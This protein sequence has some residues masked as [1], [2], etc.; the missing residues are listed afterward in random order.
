MTIIEGHLAISPPNNVPV[1]DIDPYDVEI[2]KN[3]GEYYEELIA[4][5]PFVYIPKYSVLACGRYQEVKEVFSDWKRFVSSRGVGLNDF[6]LQKPWRDPSIILEADP[7]DHTKTRKILSRV[8]SPKAVSALKENFR[9]AAESLIDELLKREVFDAV[10]DM[11]EVFPTSVFPDFVGLKEVNKRYLIDYGA[12]VFNALGPDN[13]LR[14]KAMDRAPEIVS[15]IMEQCERDNLSKH[16]MGAEIYSAADAGEITE[17]EAGMLVR[18]LLS[19]GVDTTVTGIGSGIYCLAH[20]PDQFALL[21]ENPALARQTFE[22]VLRFT[23]PVHSFCRTANQDTT[24]SDVKIREGTKIICVLGAANMDETKWPEATKFDVGRK[25]IGHLAFGTG[26]HGCVG[27][28]IARG[29]VEAILTALARKVDTIEPAG[30]AVWRP[31]N[32]IHALGSFPVTFN[33]N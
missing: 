22:E 32:A 8:L 9:K 18:S 26:I 19:A 13:K 14:R 25:P 29:E 20:N 12:T 1:W 11:A 33:N 17:Q 21:K 3:P 5:G 28:N 31:N 7:P 4:K 24:V 10:T 16:G 23:S 15:W 6:K 2:L 30:E 27:Q